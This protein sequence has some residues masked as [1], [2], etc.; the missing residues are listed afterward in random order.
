MDMDTIILVSLSIMASLIIIGAILFGSLCESLY[1]RI[2]LIIWWPYF[3][4]V[5]DEEPE[6]EPPAKDKDIYTL[7]ASWIVP[8]EDIMW[9]E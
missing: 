7:Q 2:F 5:K 6:K 3:T 4:G 9:L 1:K 8:G